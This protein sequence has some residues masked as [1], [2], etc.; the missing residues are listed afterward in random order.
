MSTCRETPKSRFARTRA[1]GVPR[2]PRGQEPYRTPVMAFTSGMPPL[3]AFEPSSFAPSLNHSFSWPFFFQL[4]TVA[5]YRRTS[6]LSPVGNTASTR[7][8]S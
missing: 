1:A 3:T 4:R 7:D 2:S 5:P 8:L 6:T